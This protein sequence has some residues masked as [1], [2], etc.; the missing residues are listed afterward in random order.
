MRTVAKSTTEAETSALASAVSAVLYQRAALQDLTVYP[1]CTP[2]HADPSSHELSMAATSSPST[3][4]C[5]SQSA[6]K[7]VARH[8]VTDDSKHY[9]VKRA[10]IRYWA[11]ENP[12]VDIRWIPSKENKSD[13]GTK[14]FTRATFTMLRNALYHDGPVD[15][16]KNPPP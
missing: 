4:H 16:T 14:A 2:V 9:G 7:L 1:G 11:H 10:F 12:H 5:D 3:I 15:S 8:Q 13:I 6:I